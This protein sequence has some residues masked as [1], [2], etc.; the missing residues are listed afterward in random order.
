VDKLMLL[1]WK[2]GCVREAET[3]VEIGVREALANAIIHGN[4]ENPRKRVHIRCRGKPDGVSIAVK[5]EG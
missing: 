3:D 1:S 2:C 5:D 4:H